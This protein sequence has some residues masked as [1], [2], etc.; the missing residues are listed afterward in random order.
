[1]QKLKEKGIGT[2]VHYKPINTQPYYRKLLH[3]KKLPGAEQ[4][5][6][7]TLSYPFILKCLKVMWKGF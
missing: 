1:M 2:Q 7:S 3:N 5:F 6:K 4:Y